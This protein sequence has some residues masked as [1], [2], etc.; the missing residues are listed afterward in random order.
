[1]DKAGIKVLVV[2]DEEDII[3]FVAKFLRHEGFTAFEALGGARALEIFHEERPQICILEVGPLWGHEFNGP[4][5]G[6]KINGM[7][8]LKE[9]KQTDPNVVC[10]VITV[11]K[12]PETEIQAKALGANHYFHKPVTHEVWLPTI[13]TAAEQWLTHN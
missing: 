10:I 6:S 5:W 3:H 12:D 1:M 7:D 13:K 2:D 4:L 9:I 8:V 11:M